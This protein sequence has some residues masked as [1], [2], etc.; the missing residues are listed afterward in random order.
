MDVIDL[1]DDTVDLTAGSPASA[2]TTT[3][4]EGSAG[5]VGI[6]DTSRTPIAELIG[7]QLEWSTVVAADRVNRKGSHSTKACLFCDLKYTG[8][9]E[10]VLCSFVNTWTRT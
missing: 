7:T 3:V 4:S 5:E 6:Q 10:G 1:S 9:P 8:G 2:G